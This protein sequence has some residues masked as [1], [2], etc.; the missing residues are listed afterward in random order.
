MDYIINLFKPTSIIFFIFL[1][2]TLT[3]FLNKTKISK[4]IFALGI[5]IFG[6]LSFDPIAEI[7]LNYFEK[8]Y[9]SFK[10]KNLDKKVKYIVVLA[11]GFSPNKNHH[12]SSNL[13]SR[14]LTRLVEGV[15]IYNSIP[16]TK[17]I[18]TGKGWAKTT[19]AEA[20]SEL[21]TQLGV[22]KIDI[23]TESESENTFE[24]SIKLKPIIKD[25]PFILVTSALHMDRAMGIFIKAGYNPIP[26]PSDHLLKG[27]YSL[28]RVNHYSPESEN[29][30]A[31]DIW[32]YELMAKI[33]STIRGRI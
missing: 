32:F 6:A 28:F 9:T 25:D 23:I 33:Y 15:A 3:L 22:P 13:S 12:M 16:N 1:F 2:G 30:Y 7:P 8:K 18:V 31:S 20:M 10:L 27:E 11:G 29:L 17:L 21:A 5:I 19:E 26:A 14:T 24:H 4:F